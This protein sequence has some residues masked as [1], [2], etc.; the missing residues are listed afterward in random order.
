[1]YTL[2]IPDTRPQA[3]SV[4][5]CVI[6]K[7]APLTSTLCAEVH[8]ALHH[9]MIHAM[10]KVREDKIVNRNQHY[11]IKNKLAAIQYYQLHTN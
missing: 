3:H 9:S 7:T 4:T 10:I 5:E 2:N 11:V 1:M 6:F 8:V